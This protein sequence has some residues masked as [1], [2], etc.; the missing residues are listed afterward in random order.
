MS[1]SKVLELVCIYKDA[2]NLISKTMA[3]FGKKIMTSQCSMA[4]LTHHNMQPRPDWEQFKQQFPIPIHTFCPD[5]AP[6]N[7]YYIIE[8]NK[9][10]VIA[11]CDHN[12]IIL[13]LDSHDLASCNGNLHYFEQYLH[14]AIKSK[15]LTL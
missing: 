4:I 9:P 15:F 3:M 11:K 5:K 7:L 13:L 2:R 1:K 14:T 12:Q 6:S 10:C 8:K